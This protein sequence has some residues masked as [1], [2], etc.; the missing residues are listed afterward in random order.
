MRGVHLTIIILLMAATLLFVLQNCDVVTISFL[1]FSI[2][3][4]L[5][6]L[7]AIVYV[8]GAVTGQLVCATAPI[9]QRLATRSLALETEPFAG[10]AE[11]ARFIA[12]SVVGHDA[13][14][15]D[16]EFGVVDHS[17]FQEGDS[18][19]LALTFLDLGIG[20]A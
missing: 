11:G 1:G 17:G 18:A 12:R 4:P 3:A 15:A 16:A 9:L 7:T 13:L 2:R 14:N 5:A 8:I 10:S 6:I 19:R 20:D